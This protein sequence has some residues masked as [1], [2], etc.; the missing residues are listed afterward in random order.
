T[1]LLMLVQIVLLPVYLRWFVGNEF[2]RGVDLAPFVSTFF[3]LIVVPLAL[4]WATQWAAI[5]TPVANRLQKRTHAAMVPLMMLTLAVVVV[6]QISEVSG[7]LAR[8]IVVVPV[9]V[10]F[11]ICM[12]FVG[13]LVGRIA[14]L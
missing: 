1:P 13:I 14:G 6:S 11:A 2:V 9:F 5:H 3:W 10:A 8:L 12:V 7:E 4:A